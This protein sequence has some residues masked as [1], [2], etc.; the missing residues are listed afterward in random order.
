MARWDKF[1]EGVSKGYGLGFN[2]Y[3]LYDEARRERQNRADA[4]AA[5]DAHAAATAAPQTQWD[6]Q[7]AVPTQYGP[8]RS[9]AEIQGAATALPTGGPQRQPSRALEADEVPSRFA[10]ADA[11]ILA[12]DLS[13][14]YADLTR[15]QLGMGPTIPPEEPDNYIMAPGA[16]GQPKPLPEQGVVLDERKVDKQAEME[17]QLG[18]I[19]PNN[20]R[21][22]VAKAVGESAQL[23]G[24]GRV[25]A[26][27]WKVMRD[28]LAAI[29]ARNGDLEGMMM[30][31]SRIAEMQQER[32]MDGLE[33][34]IRLAQVDPQ[35]AA[36]ELYK[37]YSYFPDGVDVQ[38]T[39]RN[40]QLVGYGYDEITGEFRGGMVLDPQALAGLYESIKD[41]VAFNARRIAQSVAAEQ[42]AYDREKDRRQ[43]ELDLFTANSKHQANLAA[44]IKSQA[45]AGYSNARAAEIY[46]NEWGG[47]KG[48][49]AWGNDFDGLVDAHKSFT[50]YVGDLFTGDLPPH[51]LASVFM[52]PNTSP[53]PPSQ[54][55][56]VGQS[57]I[58]LNGKGLSNEEVMDIASE[59][60]LAAAQQ[61]GIDLKDVMEDRQY[62]EWARTRKTD[63]SGLIVPNVTVPNNQQTRM[64]DGST[65][66]AFEY[67]GKQMVVRADSMG[68]LL[69]LA[70][71]TDQTQAS[72][73]QTERQ[74]ERQ[75]LLDV[76]PESEGFEHP[77]SRA[78]SAFGKVFKTSWRDTVEKVGLPA[79]LRSITNAYNNKIP[80]SQRDVG[81][82]MDQMQDPRYRKVL[83]Q[84]LPPELFRKLE[85]IESTVAEG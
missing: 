64:P 62:E 20:V 15:E 51:S 11:G 55:A 69:A 32:M 54:V 43:Y 41:P 79:A 13:K 5:M 4:Q 58:S 26:Q 73:P 19:I 10:G 8:G 83:K 1:L 17:A 29:Y 60:T 78:A 12:G 31:D 52:N 38:I 48:Q 81:M 47:V 75:A 39:V 35:A 3:Q 46:A 33:N 36:Q 65:V 66:V 59:L 76:T 42:L 9:V 71:A 85:D 82:L 84:E 27:N 24:D 2:R 63:A 49:N 6:T 70:N 23:T 56:K 21:R 25:R 57:I 45:D 7:P 67:H 50:D 80:I 18:E 37:A 28:K 61:Q 22:V 16:A 74:A 77:V 40:G 34:A 72:V 68:G 44:I 14:D 30:L 53:V